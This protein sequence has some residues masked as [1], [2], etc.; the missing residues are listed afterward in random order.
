MK[1]DYVENAIAKQEVGET[2]K[3]MEIQD[4]DS[5]RTGRNTRQKSI[6]LK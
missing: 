2:E 4:D 6:Q 1:V 5:K 3:K